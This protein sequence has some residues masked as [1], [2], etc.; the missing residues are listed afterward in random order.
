MI[1]SASRRTDIPAFYSEWLEKRLREGR[2]QIPNPYRPH[3]VRELRF[4]PETVDCAVFW[5]KDARPLL[6]RLK[7][8][9]KMGYPFYFQHTLTP[10][11]PELEPGLPLKRAVLDGMR[12]IGEAY[13]PDA[14]VWRYDPIVLGFGWSAERHF[15]AFGQLC[16]ALRGAAG[17]CVVSFLDLYP[18]RMNCRAFAEIPMEERERLAAGFGKIAAECALPL[19]ACAEAGDYRRYGIAPSACIDSVLVSKA[20]GRP[21]AAG[22]DRNQR[23]SCGC[24]A[25]I[26]IGM[27]GSCPHG[28]RYCY[29]SGNRQLS[30][31][32]HCPDSPRLLGWQEPGDAV[33]P[34]I[35]DT[36]GQLSLF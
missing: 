15:E 36:A 27:Y 31:R 29:A 20:A 30:R 11:G 14:L 28:C 6:P 32:A 10:Y 25:S 17:R 18:G 16:R 24:A 13:G 35:P 3:Q 1:L 23:P 19:Y 26:D 9:A 4:S 2:V 5:T 12:Q 21:V 8:I 33:T 34:V 22:K 7:D